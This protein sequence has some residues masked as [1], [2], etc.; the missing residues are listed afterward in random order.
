MTTTFWNNWKSFDEMI[1]IDLAMRKQDDC[2]VFTFGLMGFG[3]VL[4]I[5]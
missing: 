4:I 1:L 2:L 3:M 5:N